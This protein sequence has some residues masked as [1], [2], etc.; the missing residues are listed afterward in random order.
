VFIQSDSPIE[1]RALEFFELL[2]GQIQIVRGAL[3]GLARNPVLLSELQELS[4]KRDRVLCL[5]ADVGYTAVHYT[6]RKDPKHISLRLR[7]IKYFFD[8]H[9]YLQVHRSWLVNPR[10]VDRIEISRAK[11]EVVLGDMRVPL[12]RTYL[13]NIRATHPEWFS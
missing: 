5:K 10:K 13:Q 4:A 11:S 8:D 12:S 3:K 6:N 7:S 2:I 1:K 9:W